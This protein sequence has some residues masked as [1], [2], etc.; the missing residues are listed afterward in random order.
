MKGILFKYDANPY[1]PLLKDKR[2]DKE[3]KG[4]ID[5][6]FWSNPF[7]VWSICGPYARSSLTNGSVIF[8]LPT[9]S[10]WKDA[11]IYDYICT[12][13]LVV[14]KKVNKEEFARAPT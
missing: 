8:F 9:M 11:G 12:G 5:P 4:F 6:D 1:D 7:P 2:D 10:S 3:C 14:K 13:M